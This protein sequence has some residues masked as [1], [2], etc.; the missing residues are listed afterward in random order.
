MH[1]TSLALTPYDSRLTDVA[2]KLFIYQVKD[3]RMAGRKKTKEGM[4]I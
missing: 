3:D 2:P 1:A 4:S